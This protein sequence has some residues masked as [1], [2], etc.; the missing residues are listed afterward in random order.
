MIL[1]RVLR[2][3]S[4]STLPLDFLTEPAAAAATAIADSSQLFLPGFIADPPDR[5][6]IFEMPE[7]STFFLLPPSPESLREVGERK[8]RL[9]P[10]AGDAAPLLPPAGEGCLY[11]D[12][13]MIAG[14]FA[15]LRFS[16]LAATRLGTTHLDGAGEEDL[17]VALT[18]GEDALEAAL[19]AGDAARDAPLAAGD[20]S[21]CLDGAGD[22]NRRFTDDAA[23]SGKFLGARTV[24]L[25]AA[26][27][28][29][30]AREAEGMSGGAASEEESGLMT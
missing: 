23:A 18:A 26:S 9:P 8:P 24:L 12:G 20:G 29:G 2:M 11:L 5:S 28:G 6:V 14:S 1:T 4:L 21:R 19:T 3:V 16:S 15:A 30:A 7:T 25:A 27:E 10:P 13:T 17:D 22:E